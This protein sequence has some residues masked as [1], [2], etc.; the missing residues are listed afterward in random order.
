MCTGIEIALLAGGAAAS[1]GGAMISRNEAQKNAAAVAL[2]RNQELRDSTARQRRYED[3]SR[4]EGVQK[5]LDRFSPEEQAKAQADE[6]A[7]RGEAITDAVTP[8][9]GVEDIPLATGEDNAPTV[10][11]DQIGQKL[12]DVFNTATDRAKLSAKPLSYSDVLAGNNVALTNA[13]RV[14]D[15]GNSF[16]RQEAAILPSQQDF[17]AYEAQKSPSIWGPLLTAA[18]TAAAG[19]GGSGYLSK[20]GTTA[21]TAAAGAA[22]PAAAATTFSG[23]PL[24][25]M[26]NP[27]VLR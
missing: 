20:L 1:A 9:A 3:R 14:V 19:A 12:R 26:N 22:A 16:A 21:A 23:A 15:T 6:T 11:K 24:N 5:A 13:G 4:T 2:A 27:F 10:V 17:A 18:G 8:S 7:R 25:Y